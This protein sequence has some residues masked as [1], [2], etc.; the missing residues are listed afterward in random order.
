MISV[1][2]LVSWLPMNGLRSIQE[3]K[4]L[5]WFRKNDL[6]LSLQFAEDVRR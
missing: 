3:F 1:L 5:A 4:D 6:H 2:I